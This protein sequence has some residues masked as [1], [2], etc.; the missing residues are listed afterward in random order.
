MVLLGEEFYDSGE[1]L[2]LSFEC[3]GTWLVSMVIVGGRH[4]VSKYHVTLCLKSGSMA[5]K[6]SHR[7]HQLMMSKIVSKSHSAHVL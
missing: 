2:N 6:V 5:Y 1:S 7:W 4:Q 3:S